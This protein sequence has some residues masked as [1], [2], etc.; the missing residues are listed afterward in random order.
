MLRNTFKSEI[1]YITYDKYKR[2]KLVLDFI[3]F[4]VISYSGIWHCIG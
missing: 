2:R 3:L 4:I 1:L